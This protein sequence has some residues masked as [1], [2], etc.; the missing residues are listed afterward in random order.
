MISHFG[1]VISW[2]EMKHWTIEVEGL[3]AERFEVSRRIP[4]YKNLRDRNII[5]GCDVTFDELKSM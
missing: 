4:D 2:T 1:D 3:S 5:G